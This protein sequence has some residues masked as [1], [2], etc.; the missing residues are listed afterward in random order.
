MP[1]YFNEDDVARLVPM[2]V[3]VARVE[4]AFRLLGEGEAQSRP[5]VR[6]RAG[7]LVLHVMSGGSGALGYLGLKAYTTG[8]AGARFYVLLFDA[9]DGRLVSIIGAD[10]LGQ[11]RTGAAS[12]VATRYL[13]T[14]DASCVGIYGTGWQARSQLEAISCVRSLASVVAFGRDEQRR[15]SFCREM[16]EILGI[17]VEAAERPEEVSAR[18]EILVTATNAREPVLFGSWLRPGQH[19]NAIGSNSLARREIDEAVVTRASL[20][21]A[22][23]VEQAKIECGDLD[24]VVRAGKLSWDRVCELSEVVAGKL[25]GRHGADDITLFES[26]GLAIEDV[27]LA[28]VV[29]ERGRDEGSGREIEL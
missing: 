16:S 23:S 7:K 14:E 2:A 20:V 15:R 3:A 28:K 26:Q 21:A 27:A 8:P 13:A 1:L 9:E 4:E 12:G 5:R 19:V 24:A 10:R 11:I 18:A 6:S 17:P 22:D 29:Y 25:A